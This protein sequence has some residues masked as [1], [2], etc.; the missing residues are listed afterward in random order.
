[1]NNPETNTNAERFGYGT[2]VVQAEKDSIF[3][4]GKL[5]TALVRFTPKADCRFYILGPGYFHKV[6]GIAGISRLPDGLRLTEGGI[7]PP[8]SGKG[9]K[10]NPSPEG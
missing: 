7:V 8:S 9:G 3:L 4:L 5:N 2:Y 1:M 6:S 10:D